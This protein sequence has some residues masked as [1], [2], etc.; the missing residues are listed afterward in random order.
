MHCIQRENFIAF[1]KES[2]LNLQ[3]VVPFE[4]FYFA[5]LLYYVT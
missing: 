4:F 5:T 3:H 2:L 1:C